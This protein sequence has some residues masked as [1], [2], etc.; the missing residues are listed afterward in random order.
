MRKRDIERIERKQKKMEALEKEFTMCL[1]CDKGD[2][3]GECEKVGFFSTRAGEVYF[4]KQAKKQAEK[5][6]EDE[7]MHRV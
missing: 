1:H 6:K 3:D 5:E 4:R 2:C 7:K